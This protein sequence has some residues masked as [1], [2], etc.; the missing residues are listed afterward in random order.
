MSRTDRTAPLR[1]R[2]EDGEA[3]RRLPRAYPQPERRREY[4]AAYWRTERHLERA[5][6][7]AGSEP[8]PSRPRHSV[9]WN[10]Y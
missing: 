2:R 9:L 7:R 1:I 10:L 4:R 6:L 8:E 5:A 3:P